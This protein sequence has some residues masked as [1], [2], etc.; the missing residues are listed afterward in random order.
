[1]SIITTEEMAK[2]KRISHYYCG[3]FEDRACIDNF[4]CGGANVW[5]LSKDAPQR[6]RYSTE[7][8]SPWII[9]RYSAKK[10][11]GCLWAGKMHRAI[12]K[13]RTFTLNYTEDVGRL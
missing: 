2:L 8:P 13:L 6:E 9:S 3:D 12:R 7:Y 5:A 1:M 4:A 10:I 11:W